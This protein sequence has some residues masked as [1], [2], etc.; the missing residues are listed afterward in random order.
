M[1]RKN[2]EALRKQTKKLSIKEGVA[3]SVM[4]GAGMKYITP[5][6]LAIG[7]NNTQIGFLTSI[8]SLLGNFSQLF[9]SK[10]MKNF[11]RKKIIFAGVL[12]QALMWLPI[13]VF[14][15][16]FFYKN[17]D[18]G[19]SA[20]LMIMA[21]TALVI[22]GSFVSPAWHSLM[23]DI[24]N[25]KFGAYFSTRNKITCI[26]ATLV[27]VACGLMLDYS[28]KNNLLFAGFLVLFGISFLSRVISAY[29]ISKHYEPR[30]KIREKSF[31]SL[32]DFIKKMPTNN[33]GRF[34]MFIALVGF[35]TSIAS[36]FFSVYMLK[37]LHFNYAIWMLV[38]VTNTVG[39]FLF[40]PLWGK[41][42]DKFGNLRVLKWTGLMIPLVPLLWALS[43]LFAKVNFITIVIYLIAVEFFS[44]FIWAGF[45]LSTRDF[46]Y[47]AVSRQ[48]LSL[49]VAYH[50]IINGIGIFLGAT[51]G[52][53][54]SSLNFTFLGISSF[55][56]I[57]LLS[58]IVR[59]VVYAI[60]VRKIKEVRKVDKYKDG[61][62]RRE[63]KE[64]FSPIHSR[65]HL[66][67]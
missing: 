52:G 54:V 16:L 37:E 3:C 8:P 51:L 26:V 23:R 57:F 58:G 1:K 46:I 62:F 40:M 45:D 22:F 30:L 11:S 13:I 39:T 50:N 47:D 64:M 9:N 31:F 44:G 36:P 43:F 14:G 38:I 56:V 48:K 12:L 25:K 5:Y 42:A 28:R 24:I 63:I 55:L 60:M 41:F 65:L 33:F 27:T 15:Y 34:V 61:E 18:H 53:I 20:T 49:C 4:D 67:K 19:F 21:Y 6:A 35:A 59:F 7:A 10:L 17:L 66:I 32:R 2:E 29:L